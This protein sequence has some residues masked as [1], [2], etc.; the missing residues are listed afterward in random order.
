MTVNFIFLG[1]R[2]AIMALMWAVVRPKGLIELPP[3]KNGD[4]ARI[5][6]CIRKS[7]NHDDL[8]G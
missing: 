6:P 1:T 8:C 3:F 4:G 7:L 2:R 5:Y